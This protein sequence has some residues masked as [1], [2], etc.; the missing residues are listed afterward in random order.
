MD[1]VQ[2]REEQTDQIPS[3]FVLETPPP[4]PQHEPR[5]RKSSSLLEA[6]Q[7]L[8]IERAFRVP[9]NQFPTPEAYSHP[10]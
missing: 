5:K 10:E 9:A 7:V 1:H 8:P 2:E 6:F 3:R 4:E